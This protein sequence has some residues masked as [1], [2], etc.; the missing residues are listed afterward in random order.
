MKD[1][2]FITLLQDEIKHKANL[3]RVNTY[4]IKEIALKI[5]DI[6]LPVVSESTLQRFFE[7]VPVNTNFREDTLNILSQLVGYSDWQDF[8]RKHQNNY[9][10]PQYLQ[11]DS[12]GLLMLKLCLKNG[13]IDT[14]VECINELPVPYN[15][16]DELYSVEQ[17][18]AKEDI[19]ATIASYCKKN[20]KIAMAILPE[21]AKT[22]QGQFYFYENYVSDHKFYTSA[23]EN[24]Y[25]KHI[26]RANPEFGKR[27][28]CFSYAIIFDKY[29]GEKQLKKL[30]KAGASWFNEL[31][32]E[33]VSKELL[34]EKPWIR[35][36]TCRLY[37]L[38]MRGSLSAIELD[39]SLTH[40]VENL[41]YGKFFNFV[42][43][44]LFQSLY[45]SEQYEILIDFLKTPEVFL[46]KDI[47]STWNLP[48]FRN[49][50]LSTS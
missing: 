13:N 10:I 35:Y 33:Q 40:L 42:Y 41:K 12:M 14:V 25:T 48:K 22:K 7:L 30:Y 3:V 34:S 1:Y 17:I 24:Y 32:P 11:S 50:T 16:S 47:R 28:I 6:G 31:K 26:H 38:K 29:K 2:F 21:L 18:I 4:N 44:L 19:A 49:I 27:D 45:E 36:H 23:I 15:K 20:S 39:K 5:E 37:F 46:S 8:C 43:R 9:Y